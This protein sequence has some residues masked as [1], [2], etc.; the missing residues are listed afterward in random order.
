MFSLQAIYHWEIA[1]HLPVGEE[2]TYEELAQRCSI[3]LPQLQRLLRVAV[4]NN[5]FVEPQK[6]TIAHTAISKLLAEDVLVREWVGLVCVEMLPAAF[7][8]VPAML[9][10]PASKE[11]D[12][13][14][15]ALAHGD[16]FWA[17]IRKEPS[18]ARRFAAG[19]QSLQS[20]PAFDIGHLIKSLDWDTTGIPGSLVDIGG[21]QGYVSAA[22][23]RQY[24][25]LKCYV[26]DVP[27][28]LHG[29]EAP[30]ELGDR[31]QFLA[32]DFFAEQTVK[33]ADVYLLRSVLHDWSDKY[34]AEIIRNLIPALKNG[35]K[36]IVNEVCLP[37]PNT[38]PAYH[39][40]LL[41]YVGE[42]EMI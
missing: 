29:A 22:L 27:E 18:R 2:M 30:E 21:S 7:Q 24:P 5:I 34:A 4:S 16:S 40:Q 1:T 6:G 3:D 20:H 23:L 28:V 12:Q 15:F 19:M 17:L 10:W 38:V 32:H 37:E 14:G 31:L 42:H 36:V 11:A 8:T 39:E 33:H 26:Q 9:K 41:R 35:A 13:T 25:Q